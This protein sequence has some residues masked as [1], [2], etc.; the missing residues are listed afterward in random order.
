M[1][2]Y[3][4]L[5]LFLLFVPPARLPAGLLADGRLLQEPLPG[6][7]AAQGG[8]RSPAGVQGDPSERHPGAE[9]PDDQ[10]HLRR[11]LRLQSRPPSTRIVC[12]YDI[13]RDSADSATCLAEPA[14]PASHAVPAAV[15]PPP[16]E[17]QQA[18]REGGVPVHRQQLQPRKGAT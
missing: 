17:R 14:G 1:P 18:Q 3:R 16:R 15:R 9:G 5:F 12:L 10:A 2:L 6:G 8:E 13:L 4:F 11:P 7:A